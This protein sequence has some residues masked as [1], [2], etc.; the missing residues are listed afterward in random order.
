MTLLKKVLIVLGFVAI[1]LLWQGFG[2]YFFSYP[3]L[4]FPPHGSRILLWGDSLSVGVG[5]SAP[6]KGYVGVLKDRLSLDITNK[7]VSGETSADALLHAPADLSEVNPDIVLILLGGND[8]LRGT[9]ASEMFANLR[10]LIDLA[11][12]KKA[13]V[14][15]VGIKK[16]I[17][18]G[19]NDGFEKLAKDSG[20]LYTPDILLDIFGNSTLMADEIHPNDKGYLK[21]ADKLAPMLESIVMTGK[22]SSQSGK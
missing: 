13:V 7:A 16:H 18:D 6:E 4:N 9:P 19:Y 20:S 14:Y 1:V 11:H 8:M 17:G 12:E 2:D 5:A 21:M 15:L 22:E 10:K 3:I